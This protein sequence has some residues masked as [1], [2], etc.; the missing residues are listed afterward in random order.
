[1]LVDGSDVAVL[2]LE[3]ITTGP[4][5]QDIGRAVADLCHESGFMGMD[6]QK[7]TRFVDGYSDIR[8]LTSHERDVLP[9]AAIFGCTALAAQ[10][11]VKRLDGL[12]DI[13]LQLGVS[14]EP[15]L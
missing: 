3:T 13:F 15:R 10:L 9:A 8:P 11:Y 14:I 7:V 5:V 2:D 6:D 4:F 12:G 1:V